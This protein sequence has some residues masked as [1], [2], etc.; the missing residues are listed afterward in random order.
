MTTDLDL[1]IAGETLQLLP[2]RALL[3]RER[4]VLV[5]S[6]LHLGKADTHRSLGIDIPEGVVEESLDR[7]EQ[8]ILRTRAGRVV[9]LGDLVQC[10]EGME[11]PVVEQFERWRRRVT[12]PISLIGGDHELDV[13][14]PRAWRIDD[15]GHRLRIG[16]FLLQHEPPPSADGEGTDFVLAGHRHPVLSVGSGARR[17]LAHAFVLDPH[18]VIL[19]AFTPFARGARVRPDA[20]RSRRVFVI[21]D[22]R[23]S[24]A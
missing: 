19:P 17:S 5:L 12:L 8:A 1:V 6:D 11:E 22:G 10:E 13:S 4:S 20:D 3:L 23:V 18:Q 14:I 2:E 7:L 16:P 9:I 15:D 24:E 21:S